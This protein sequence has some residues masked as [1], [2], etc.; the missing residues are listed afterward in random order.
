MIERR[1]YDHHSVFP[2]FLQQD[3]DFTAGETSFSLPEAGRA[4]VVVEDRRRHL[5]PCLS[6][7]T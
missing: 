1:T 3:M 4:A 6:G 5:P 7:L 2:D